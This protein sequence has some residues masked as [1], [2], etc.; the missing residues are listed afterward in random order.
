MVEKAFDNREVRREGFTTD[1]ARWLR[2]MAPL[3]APGNGTA[4]G[5][6][7]STEML[8]RNWPT[9]QWYARASGQVGD[10]A[11][12]LLHDFKSE[13]QG[14]RDGARGRKEQQIAEEFLEEF[15][16]IPPAVD[17][18]ESLRF[19]MGSPPDEAERWEKEKLYETSVPGQFELA[20]H[21]VTNQQYELF[22]PAHHGKR[23]EFS[24][25]DRCPVIYVTWYDAWAFCR[26]LGE[27]FRLPSDKE[28]EF[29]CRAG[30]TTAF[31]YGDSLSSN[32]ANFDGVYPYGNAPKGPYLER[33]APV[34]SYEPNEWG[35]YDMH[36][37]VWEWC[38]TW[39]HERAAE[40][41]DPNYVGSARVL[42]GGSWYNNARNTRAAIR[43]NTQPTNSNNNVGFRAAKALWLVSS[44]RV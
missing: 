37:N 16:P 13:F 8:Y 40:A 32:R 11:R 21:A 23:D 41:D 42:R 25:E 2:A 26:W 44:F 33:T 3:Y 39:Y 30:T 6:R 31:H 22:G 10:S 12:Q 36:G 18:P 28:W 17:S 35:L 19:R 7:R 5:T 38:E 15:R 43:N 14:I 9:M 27:G 1:S 4:E 20:C 34:G 24:T 29:A